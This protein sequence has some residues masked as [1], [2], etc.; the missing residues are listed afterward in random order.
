MNTNEARKTHFFN[1]DSAPRERVHCVFNTKIHGH[2]TKKHSADD[3]TRAL[4]SLFGGTM[5]SFK[6]PLYRLLEL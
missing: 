3:T 2:Y 1:K 4:V 6:S 5:V